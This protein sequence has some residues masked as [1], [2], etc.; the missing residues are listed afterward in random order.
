M[1]EAGKYYHIFNR[2]NNREDIFKEEKN[3]AYF[4]KLYEHHIGPIA[5]TYAYCLMKNHFHLLVKIREQK[6]LPVYKHPPGLKDLE[7]VKQI[8]DSDSVRDRKHLPGFRNLEGVQHTDVVPNP[9]RTFSNLFNAYT[10]S[11][12]KMYGRTGSLFEKNFRRIEVDSDLYF[13]RLVHYIHLNPQK[14][15]FVDDFRSYPHSSYQ[16]II[17]DAE[18]VLQRVKVIEW[19]GGRQD[20]IEWHL[21]VSNEQDLAK[22]LGP[23]E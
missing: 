3:Y 19:F 14:H 12:N 10:K 9:S 23:D 1:L 21:K 15:G 8:S 5:E 2:G 22:Y 13:A 20:L 17:S 4:L 16:I 7:G 18:T 11:I 6:N